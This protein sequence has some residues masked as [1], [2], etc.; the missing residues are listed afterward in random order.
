MEK[1]YVVVR[2]DLEPGAQLAQSCH[3]LSAFAVA[4]PE[5]HR[6]WHTGGQ[7]LV[8][9]SVADESELLILFARAALLVPAAGFHEPDFGGTLTAIALGADARPLVSS[10]PL[11]LRACRAAA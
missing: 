6:D 11:A 8:V 1:L 2:R 10:L 4:H 3:A 9:L 5:L 7:N